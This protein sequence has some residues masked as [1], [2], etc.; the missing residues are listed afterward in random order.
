MREEA[1]VAETICQNCGNQVEAGTVTCP[2]CGMPQPQPSFMGKVQGA[3]GGFLATTKTHSKAWMAGGGVALVVVVLAGL[4]FGG[5]F[6]PSGRA[7]CTAALGQAKEFGVISPNATLASSSAKSTDVKDRRS[8][9]VQVDS[10]T[11]TILADIRTETL[12]HVKCKDVSQAGCVMIYSVARSDGMTTYQVREIPPGESD[13]ALAA[14]EGPQQQQQA[15]A[16]SG[17]APAASGDTSAFDTETATDN[18]GATTS[19]PS[20]AAPS[21][22]DQSQQPQQQ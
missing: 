3:V 21:G 17:I 18:S 14:S 6:G 11:F 13:E 9:S 22:G 4:Y 15:P 16:A 12:S 5:V 10:D 20:Q 8:C 7:I 1:T 19:A 2:A